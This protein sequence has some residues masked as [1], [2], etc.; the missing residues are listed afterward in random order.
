MSQDYYALYKVFKKSGP[1]PKNG[2]QY[3]AIF[4]EEDWADEDELD[5]SNKFI[6]E[7]P[8][9]QLSGVISVDISEP[10]GQ[11]SDVWDEIWNG[12]AVE[13]PVIPTYGDDY[14][15]PQAQVG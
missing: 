13:P 7:T 9:K 14:V 5:V 11:E 6:Q 3:G 15:N 4:K 1:G 10:D 12:L 8:P 2:E